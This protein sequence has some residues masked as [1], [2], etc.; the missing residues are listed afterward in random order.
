MGTRTAVAMLAALAAAAE[1]GWVAGVPPTSITQPI[2]LWET[3]LA[4]STR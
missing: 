4:Q 3:S 2:Q 1:A